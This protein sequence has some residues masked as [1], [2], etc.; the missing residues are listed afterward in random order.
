[1]LRVTVR[2]SVMLSE[3]KQTP[4]LLLFASVVFHSRQGKKGQT[5]SDRSS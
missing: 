4:Q 3:A 1:M 2:A 5:V